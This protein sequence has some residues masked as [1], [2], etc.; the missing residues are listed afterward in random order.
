[1]AHNSIGGQES[2]RGHEHGVRRPQ[3]EMLVQRFLSLLTDFWD[4]RQNLFRLPGTSLYAVQ[5][6]FIFITL[7][8]SAPDFTLDYSV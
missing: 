2:E 1:M 4:Q 6:I 8:R 5:V 7:E 3:L